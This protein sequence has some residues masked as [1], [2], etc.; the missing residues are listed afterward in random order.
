M[1]GYGWKSH[2]KAR[3][4]RETFTTYFKIII[5]FRRSDDF[6]NAVEAWK[7]ARDRFATYKV[8]KKQTSM[9]PLISEEEEAQLINTRCIH[10][11]FSVV[12]AY[13]LYLG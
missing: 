3:I 2:P 7:R 1:L 6:E 11:P 5:T 8:N 13:L 9:P 12:I 4:F 10:G